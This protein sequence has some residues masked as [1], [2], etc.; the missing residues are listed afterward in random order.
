M[1]GDTEVPVARVD[2]AP[3]YSIARVINGGWQLTPDHGDGTVEPGAVIDGFIR[4]AEAGFT[5]FDCADIY[6][7]VEELLGGFLA[8]WRAGGR[9]PDRIQIHTKYVPDMDALASLRS[10]DV[11]RAIDRSLSRLGVERLDL[12]QFHWWDYSVP[13]FVDTASRLAELQSAGKIRC[14]GLTNVA[15][16]ELEELER[17]GIWIEANQ[18]QYSTMDR[19]PE[20]GLTRLC[21][22]TG[23]Q[24]LCYG[25]LAGGFLSDRYLGELPPPEPQVNRSLTKYRLIVDEFGGW[26]ALQGLLVVLDRVARKHGVSVANVAARWV[27]ERTRVAA[28]ILGASR[29][30]RIEENKRLFDF[31]LEGDDLVEIDRFCSLHTGPRGSIYELERD[32]SGPHWAILRTGLHAD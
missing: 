15:A 24:L 9:D 7:G 32:R 16:S 30:D 17:A 14:L 6:T 4:L 1:S 18:V 29:V 23:T 20:R 10:E 31:A 28:V 21:S 11:D 13:G 22:R 19:R 2:L 25:A 8:A 5:T 12:V 26:P 27:L 3:G